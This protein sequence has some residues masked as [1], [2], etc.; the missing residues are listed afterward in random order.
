METLHTT[1]E[2]LHGDANQS[3]RCNQQEHEEG[4]SLIRHLWYQYKSGLII[5]ADSSR[6][7]RWR[8]RLFISRDGVK[9]EL[10]PAAAT[11]KVEGDADEDGY[12]M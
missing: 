9:S 4:A 6:S 5:W 7:L 2:S 10:A 12:K 1:S 3:R 8:T 11:S